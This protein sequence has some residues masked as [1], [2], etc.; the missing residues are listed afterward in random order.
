MSRSGAQHPGIASA[1]SFEG[2]AGMLLESH[3]TNDAAP[4]LV[5]MC[6]L[7]RYAN[8]NESLAH[9]SGVVERSAGTRDETTSFPPR[10]PGAATTS[11][12]QIATVA[13]RLQR[14]GAWRWRRSAPQSGDGWRQ[15]E[16]G[17]RYPLAKRA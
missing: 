14:T 17:R 1:K 4:T 7:I 3:S 2:R 8:S 5:T 9:Q 12:S 16:R 13:T 15:Q 10:A 6:G 11:Q